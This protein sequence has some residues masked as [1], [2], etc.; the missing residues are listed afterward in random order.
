MVDRERDVICLPLSHVVLNRSSNSLSWASIQ[1]MSKAA[2]KD[3]MTKDLC[4]AASDGDLQRVEQ[5][6]LKGALINSQVTSPPQLHH[7]H[8]L[9]TICHSVALVQLIMARHTKLLHSD[10]QHSCSVH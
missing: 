5:L 10:F 9:I 1:E 2:A 7:L 8:S 3:L 4:V 6:V